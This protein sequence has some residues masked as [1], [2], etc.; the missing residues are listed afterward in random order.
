MKKENILIIV[1]TV[2]FCVIFFGAQYERY[3]SWVNEQTTTWYLKGRLL[4]TPF[5]VE[6]T[7]HWIIESTRY[8][9]YGWH[10]QITYKE[11]ITLL[12]NRAI[13]WTEVKL[14]LEDATFWGNTQSWKSFKQATALTP[15]QIKN[16]SE[17]G[18]NFIH[19][20]S[21]VT[22]DAFIVS[23]A[24]LWY[25]WF[26]Q[27]REYWF[28]SRDPDVVAAMKFVFERDWNWEFIRSRRLPEWVVMCPI[29]CRDSLTMLLEQATKS[30]EIEAQYISD[31]QTIALLRTKQAQGVEI[32]IVTSNRQN[33]EP[34]EGLQWV[35][36]L[37]S[38]YVHAKNILV[39]DTLLFVWSMNLS[40][41]AIENNR[42]MSII[43]D[44]VQAIKRFNGQF[45]VDY[46]KSVPFEQ[47]WRER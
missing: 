27:N 39:D 34:L 30:I 10:Y 24:N 11:T 6:E 38:P 37:K 22:D 12:K 19:A 9:L 40:Q 35:R 45:L 7:V 21:F 3:S 46:E 44:D 5:D 47:E 16:D 15:I 43:T 25:P 26:F 42:E 20:K 17:L 13:L 18:T 23:T 32:R 2:V 29:N 33:R 31:P 14:L 28:I 4:V 36:I 1:A 41:N 8:T